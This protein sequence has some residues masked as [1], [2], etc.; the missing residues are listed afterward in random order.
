MLQMALDRIESQDWQYVEKVEQELKNICLSEPKN[1][2]L[3]GGPLL[4]WYLEEV[5]HS[6][7]TSQ[8]V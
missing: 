3:L 7:N 6:L 1:Q 5:V 2:D 8:N 4:S